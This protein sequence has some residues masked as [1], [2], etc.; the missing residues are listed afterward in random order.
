MSAGKARGRLLVISGPSG[1]GKTTICHALVGRNGIVH[2]VSATTRRPRPGEKDGVDYFFLDREEFA[3]RREAGRFL[4]WAEYAGNLYGTPRD[5]VEEQ[6]A[7]GRFPLLEI[8]V[9]GVEQLRKQGRDGIYVFLVPPSV[10]DL[11]RRLVGR[12]NTAI[13]EID[14]RVRVAEAELKRTDLYDHVVVNDRVDRALDEVLG[15]VDRE[16]KGAKA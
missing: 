15:I 4:E 10:E 1:V 6:T 16:L 12:G 5:F 11:R 3:R 13:E 2:S 7:A 9:Q 14:R 8:E